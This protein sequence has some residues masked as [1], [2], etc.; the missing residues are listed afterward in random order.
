M[1]AA[2]AIAFSFSSYFFILI[3]AG[4]NTKGLAIAFMAPVIAGVILTYR[5][6]VY[7]GAA[8]TALFLSLE[9]LA[10][11]LQITY[12]LLFVLLA[13]AV[14]EL[15]DAVGRLLVSK[16]MSLSTEEIN[17]SLLPDGTYLLKILSKDYSSS[18]KI[19]VHH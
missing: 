16:T 7:L 1:S 8:I 12:Y 11:H 3:E 18:Q 9:I 17:T 15:Y 19:I 13:L 5:G 14:I 2:G 6:R 4:H 10:N